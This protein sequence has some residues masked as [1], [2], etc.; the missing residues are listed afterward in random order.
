MNAAHF[1]PMLAA[2]LALGCGACAA[3]ARERTPDAAALEAEVRRLIGDARCSADAQC[4]TLAFGAKA[5][6][7]PQAYLAWSTQVTDEAAL[8]QA[9]QRH[10]ERRRA[11]LRQS[12]LMSDC[13][14]V[15]DPGASCMPALAASAPAERTCR[16]QGASGRRS[17]Q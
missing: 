2:A 3:P 13:A 17:A 6:G 5:C 1:G 7:G 11:D 4:R 16:L 12:G 8:L 14:V 9:A 15:A 10:A